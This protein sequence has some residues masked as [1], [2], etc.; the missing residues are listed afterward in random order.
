MMDAHV[1]WLEFYR[2]RDEAVG[3]VSISEDGLHLRRSEG[4]RL[5]VA[6]GLRLQ[7]RAIED[8]EAARFESL[9]S[10]GESNRDDSGGLEKAEVGRVAV[11]GE[12]A[13]G[14]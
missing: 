11:P 12:V 2:H 14:G 7:G 9:L 4:S 1:A 10:E 6:M 13:L 5:L 3:R 8:L